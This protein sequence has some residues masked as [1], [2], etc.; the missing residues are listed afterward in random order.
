[1]INKII[2]AV[3]LIIFCDNSFSQVLTPMN[4]TGTM[5][6]SQLT[7]VPYR[8][9]NSNSD[10][11]GSPF[12][13]DDWMP[14][15]VILY[16]GNGYDNVMLK[17]NALQNKFYFN[18]NDT[19]FELDDNVTAVNLKNKENETA[20]EF[21]KIV[22]THSKLKMTA[23]VQ[24]LASGKVPLYKQ[25]EKRIEGE[26]YTNGLITSQKKIVSHNSLWTIINNETVFVKLNSHS[27]EEL[28]S[29]KK[30]EMQKLVKTA[31]LNAKNEK[32]FALAMA[33]YNSISTSQ[34][35]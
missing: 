22:S 23:F 2:L 18:R 20:M 34:K 29:D 1:M 16:N 24:V 8:E 31:K 32:D 30:D 7:G 11:I 26:N 6:L 33:Y 13:F 5:A 28:T 17:F 9:I 14:G 35:K 3:S 27:L 12:L 10:A 25:Y 15:T 4:A 21:R 19:T